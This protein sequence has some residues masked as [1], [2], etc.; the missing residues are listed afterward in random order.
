VNRREKR[1]ND[2][3]E[4]YGGIRFATEPPETT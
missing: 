2:H 3:G 1:G 4:V